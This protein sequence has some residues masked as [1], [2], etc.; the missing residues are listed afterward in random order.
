L[1]SSSRRVRVERGSSEKG[2]NF[3]WTGF[4]ISVKI[5]DGNILRELASGPRGF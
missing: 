4:H 2:D 1:R 5:E 3:D